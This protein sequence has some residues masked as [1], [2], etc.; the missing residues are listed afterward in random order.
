METFVDPAEYSGTSYRAA[1]WSELGRTTGQGLR[2]KGRAYT[3]T[4]KRIYVKPLAKDFREQL[5]AGA[6]QGRVVQ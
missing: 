5:C 6:L 2:R 4:P 3:S 1:G